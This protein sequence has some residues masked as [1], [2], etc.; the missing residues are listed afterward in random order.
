[1]SACLP[2]DPDHKTGNAVPTKKL[3]IL[4]LNLDRSPNRLAAMTSQLN[5]LGLHWE[6]LAAID[7]T[8]IAGN[9]AAYGYSESLNR[10]QFPRILNAGEIGCFATHRRA[11][12]YILE[13]GWAGAVILE[14][15][16]TL[17]P[18]LPAA[19][20]ALENAMEQWDAVKFMSCGRKT[21]RH[22]PIDKAGRWALGCYFKTPILAGAQALTAN[23][24][25]KLLHAT[26]EFG[27]PV[28]VVLQWWWETGVRF[29]AL[30]PD[31]ATHGG[32]SSDI[33]FGGNR[34]DAPRRRW[35]R[36]KRAFIYNVTVLKHAI[37]LI[38][39]H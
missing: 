6:R 18:E 5:R 35:I 10:M 37:A 20:A 11:W 7:G 29:Q 39:R 12:Q 25:K 15:D 13:K 17:S 14:D 31:L 38:C 3:G 28:D 32:F 34:R 23:A 4:V 36:L 30:K 33:N 19:I 2:S 8:I 22:S 26:Q 9:T 21:I 16:V 24:A 1:M 27:R